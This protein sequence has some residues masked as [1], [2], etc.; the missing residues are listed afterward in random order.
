MLNDHVEI[1]RTKNEMT[2]NVVLMVDKMSKLDAC[3]AN[4]KKTIEI[5]VSLILFLWSGHLLMVMFHLDLHE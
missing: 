4:F 1:A 5:S 2:E 3:V